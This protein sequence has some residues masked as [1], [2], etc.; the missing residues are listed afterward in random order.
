MFPLVDTNVEDI[1]LH[2]VPS[3]KENLIVEEE[4]TVANVQ[5]AYFSNAWQEGSADLLGDS[6]H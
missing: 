1:S 3:G 6:C 2:E 4:R 5:F